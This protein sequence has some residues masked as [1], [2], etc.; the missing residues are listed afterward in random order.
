M[1]GPEW[2]GLS[3]QTWAAGLSPWQAIQAATHPLVVS[4]EA[5][6][7]LG[8]PVN[9]FLVT[10]T[11]LA[12]AINAVAIALVRVWNPSREERPRRE[13]TAGRESIWGL[14]NTI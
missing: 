3:S 8:A 14:P 9:L 4:D 12:L 7:W 10:A 13:E 5:L 1:L 11:A 6:G 2:F